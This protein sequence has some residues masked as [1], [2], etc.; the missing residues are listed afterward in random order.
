M[1]CSVVLVRLDT[2]LAPKAIR[3][4]A[5][6]LGRD[7]Y[8]L[9][10]VLRHAAPLVLG[11]TRTREAAEAAAALL[12]EQGA[13]AYAIDHAAVDAVA[14]PELART[15]VFHDECLEAPLHG[16]D[17]RIVAWRDAALLVLGRCSH[18]VRY[19]SRHIGVRSLTSM[20]RVS[21]S[22]ASRE[23]VA[24][25][26]D[27]YPGDGSRPVR[28]DCRAFSFGYLGERGGTSDWASLRTTVE[29][30]R[31][32]AGNVVVDERFEQ[33]R[34]SGGIVSMSRRAN[35]ARGVIGLRAVERSVVDE[36]AR[37]DFYSRLVY[38]VHRRRAEA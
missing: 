1:G 29:L 15:F 24:E 5:L 35:S 27:L 10:L 26:L 19:R 38:L 30:L 14:T 2:R 18:R 7:A 3:A 28:V 23:G 17:S 8:G 16:H 33:F 36:G 25:L 6:A 4:V 13:E 21:M 22:G 32:R 12:V 34:R 37:F 20:N 31:E 9:R 11:H